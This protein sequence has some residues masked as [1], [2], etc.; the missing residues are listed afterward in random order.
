VCGLC[1]G[2]K[3]L[4]KSMV[5]TKAGNLP[6]KFVFHLAP[7]SDQKSWKAALEDCFQEADK[8]QMTSLVLPPVGTGWFVLILLC[9]RL[10]VLIGDITGLACPSVYLSVPRIQASNS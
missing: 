2:T 7:K 4:T 6:C 5:I 1:R 9:C 10:E 8:L 3:G